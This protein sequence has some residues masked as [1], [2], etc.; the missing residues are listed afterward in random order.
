M[1][2]SLVLACQSLDL[3]RLPAA[4]GRLNLDRLVF[5]NESF[6]GLIGLP[7]DRL[8]GEALCQ[9][10]K[11]ESI[12]SLATKKRTSPIEIRSVS[13]RM[14]LKG[15]AAFADEGLVYLCLP[16]AD[17]PG[18]EFKD[19]VIFGEERERQRLA[20]YFHNQLAPELM[21]LA[22]SIE[23]IGQRLKQHGYH[24]EAELEPLPDKLNKLLRSI[25]DSLLNSGNQHGLAVK[26]NRDVSEN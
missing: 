21:A 22:F 25:R 10:V 17:E 14:D 16:A 2:D 1:Y 4:I 8:F 13:K 3:L 7:R 6:L 20:F 9:F 11:F 18:D 5:A 19:G 15:Y 26:Q 12:P 24:A 23:A